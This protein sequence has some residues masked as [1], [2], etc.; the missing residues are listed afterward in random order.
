LGWSLLAGR[1]HGC[2]HIGLADPAAF[3][4]RVETCLERQ[5]ARP[6]RIRLHELA[7]LLL[8]AAPGGV[9]LLLPSASAGEEP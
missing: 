3:G 6:E 1:V 4:Q 7:L 9:E 2:E 5:L 8:A